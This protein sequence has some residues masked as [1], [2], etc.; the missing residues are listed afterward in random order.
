MRVKGQADIFRMMLSGPQIGNLGVCQ[1][2]AL[3]VSAVARATM[4]FSR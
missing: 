3:P 1:G 4:A 2:M